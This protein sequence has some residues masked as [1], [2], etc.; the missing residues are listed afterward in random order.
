MDG[1]GALDLKSEQ[2]G[3]QL[4]WQHESPIFQSTGSIQECTGHGKTWA[5]GKAEALPLFCEDLARQSD[6]PR[7]PREALLAPEPQDGDQLGPG[8]THRRQP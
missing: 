2:I 1:E 5:R 4:K 7:W 8:P 6:F 3:F